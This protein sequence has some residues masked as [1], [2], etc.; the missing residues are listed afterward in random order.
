MGK[1]ITTD[2]AGQRP[3]SWWSDAETSRLVNRPS[4]YQFVASAIMLGLQIALLLLSS[5]MI[6]PTDS[7]DEKNILTNSSKEVGLICC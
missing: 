4:S 7:A 6:E 1:H 2:A 3:T 5:I